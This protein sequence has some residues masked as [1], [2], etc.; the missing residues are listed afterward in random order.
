MCIRDT[1]NV[2]HE[3]YYHVGKKWGHQNGKRFKGRLVGPF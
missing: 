1:T 3:M 2:E